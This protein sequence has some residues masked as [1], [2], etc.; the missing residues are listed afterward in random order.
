MIKIHTLHKTIYLTDNQAVFKSSIDTIIETIDSSIEMDTKYYRLMAKNEIKTIY[1]Y[2]KNLTALFNYFTSLFRI[3]EA[4]GGLVQNKNGEWL[5][6]F[7][8]GK[9]DLPKGKIEKGEAI[10][11]A[12][13][14]EVEEECGITKLSIIKELPS[15]YH[16]YFLEEKNILKR[17]YWFEMK[18][19]DTSKLKPQTEEGITDVRWISKNNLTPIYANTYNSI[20][21]VLQHLK[22]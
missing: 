2:N 10:K 14:R 13:I 18:C 4:A 7:R 1:F 16:T 6:I 5:F 17:T 22:N 12:A 8:N 15:T 3:I 21:D 20:L 11:T 9:W 19:A